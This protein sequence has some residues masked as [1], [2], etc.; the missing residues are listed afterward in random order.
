MVVGLNGKKLS[1]S[2]WSEARHPSRKCSGSAYEQP[3]KDS[4][5]LK[6]HDC[7]SLITVKDHLKS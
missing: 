6:G 7:S 2:P 3:V 5:T 4:E 1:D